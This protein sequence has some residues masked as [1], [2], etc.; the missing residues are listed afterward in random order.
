MNKHTSNITAHDTEW[1]EAYH[2]GRMDE[3]ADVVSWLLKGDYTK[4][5]KLS[6]SEL[7]ACF[8]TGMHKGAAEERAKREG[9]G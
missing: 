2:R 8:G 9:D 7:A 6:K 1:H 3:R 5:L 4:I